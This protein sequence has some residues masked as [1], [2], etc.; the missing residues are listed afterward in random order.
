MEERLKELGDP[1]GKQTAEYW[2]E[3]FDVVCGE[4]HRP[5]EWYCDVEEVVRMLRFHCVPACSGG[6]MI[7][8]GSGNSLVPV[9]LRNE[10]GFPHRHVVVDISGIALTEMK[11]F[12]DLN[13][14][15]ANEIE[16]LLGNILEP[17]LP[18]IDNS[19][20]VWVDKGL[21]DAL[22]KDSSEICS[23]QS[24][25]LFA[26]ASRLLRSDD[27]LLLVVTMAETHSLQLIL[28]GFWRDLKM[29][30]AS[31]H[32]WELEPVSGD[33]QPFGFALHRKN[34]SNHPLFIS[35]H[36]IDNQ[37]EEFRIQEPTLE[38]LV[39]EIAARC[40]ASRI[41]FKRGREQQ[42]DRIVATIE[43]KPWDSETDLEM[44]KE[45]IVKT[46]WRAPTIADQAERY[47]DP[48]WQ[49]EHSK[50]VPIGYGVCKLVLQ[51]TV[52]SEDIDDLVAA[53][54]E[55]EGTPDIEDGVQSV[56]V[57]WTKT[58]RISALP[59]TT[60]LNPSNKSVP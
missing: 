54:S 51:C 43:V 17:P 49:T 39:E 10:F 55:W 21:V 45:I 3:W 50:V 11:E 27:S 4:D 7:H 42:Q 24:Q 52:N 44:L 28:N 1:S 22:F 23:G 40:D 32:V 25:N 59:F 19:F 5:F 37:I 57:D 58:A 16:Y 38:C 36:L 53:I 30:L 48:N 15:T 35:W 8:P 26:E 47:I 12:H 14:C 33:M 41:G 13:S 60:I 9:K 31:L 29:N 56:D 46:K 34:S 20:D 2:D 6:R 18:L